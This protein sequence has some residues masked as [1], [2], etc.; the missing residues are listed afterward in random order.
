MKGVEV[1]TASVPPSASIE[2]RA[3]AL[4]ET[5]ASA[6]RGRKVNI[7]AWVHSSLPLLDLSNLEQS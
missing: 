4:A 2:T 6:A 7:I 5:I 1:I 3:E